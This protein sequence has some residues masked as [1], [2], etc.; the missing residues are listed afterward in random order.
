MGPSLRWGDGERLHHLAL[1]LLRSGR[2]A[3]V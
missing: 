1:F 3:G 2:M